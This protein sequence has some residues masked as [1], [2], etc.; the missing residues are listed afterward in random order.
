MF[1]TP[2]GSRRTAA[3]STGEMRMEQAEMQRDMKREG[4]SCAKGVCTATPVRQAPDGYSGP[5]GGSHVCASC[6]KELVDYLAKHGHLPN[7]D[8][9]EGWC[10]Q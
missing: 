1:Q 6:Y 10:D 9:S 2:T 8:H 5:Y 7:E 4:A 3:R